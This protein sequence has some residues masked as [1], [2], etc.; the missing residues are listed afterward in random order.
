MILQTIAMA[1]S[2]VRGNKIRSMLTM[3]GVIIGVLSVVVLIGIGQ[4][5]TADVT[6]SI[7][8]MGTNLLTVTISNRQG[9]S[10]GRNTPSRT[11]PGASTS[12]GQQR[13][14]VVLSMD[15][16]L[17]LEED[18]SIAAI[19]PTVS[20]NLT[21][22]A[23]NVNDSVSVMGV[24]PSYAQIRNIGVQEGRYIIQHDVDNRSAV[25]IVGT[26]VAAAFFGNTNVVGNTLRIEGRPF[27]IIGV[28]ESKG[29][30]ND[31]TVILP[32]TLA[33]RMLESTTISSFYASAVDADHVSQAQTVIENYLYKRYA[34]TN[35]YSVM[36]Q[37]EMLST[38]NETTATLTMMLGGI[39]A[40]SLLVGGIG[41]MNIMLVS[42]AERTKEIGIR[43]AIGARRRDI[44]L[45]FLVEA[46]IISG[47][48]GLLGLGLGYALLEILGRLLDMTMVFSSGVVQLA[49]G[50]SMAVGVVFGSYPAAKAAKLRPIEAL[51][52]D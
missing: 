26:E 52:Y 33:Q 24:L 30:S 14:T 20:G 16:I 21:A 40:I 31:S 23:G 32:F 7:E 41:I 17:G 49:L 19:S 27:K 46:I 51:R 10:M 5:T 15:D 45:Q 39:A 9:G 43:K 37:S 13:G 47:A 38:I 25:C 29:S 4:G 34:N 50:F 11:A 42:V 6:S 35:S 18:E 12:S 36:N 2:A 28:L 48:G 22:K 8:G 3:L 1:F 44:L